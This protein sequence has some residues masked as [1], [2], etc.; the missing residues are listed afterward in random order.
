MLDFT[1]PSNEY[2]L[3][4]YTKMKNISLEQKLVKKTSKNINIELSDEIID[5]NN[6]IIDN[7][8]IKIY[9]S[10]RKRAKKD[11]PEFGPIDNI[12]KIID[13]RDINDTIDDA[14]KTKSGMA[15]TSYQ[16]QAL[17]DICNYLEIS[18][19][20]IQEYLGFKNVNIDQLKK[21]QLIFIITKRL[22]IKRE[23]LH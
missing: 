23:I 20:T 8:D 15:I 5:Y 11:G 19:K 22:D 21:E 7:N 1:V 16:K 17:Q 2:T 6:N 13:L 18:T 3:N 4:E 14:R 12:F 10:Y 9:G